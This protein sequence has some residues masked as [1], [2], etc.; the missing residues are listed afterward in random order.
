MS[1]RRVS[2]EDA[3]SASKAA[4]GDSNP[5][6]FLVLSLRALWWWIAGVPATE[7]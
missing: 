2:F 7:Q 5:M 6:E 3:W 1:R 4:T